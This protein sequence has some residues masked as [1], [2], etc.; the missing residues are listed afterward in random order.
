MSGS[1][2]LLLAFQA[3]L[4]RFSVL[5]KATKETKIKNV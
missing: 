3:T 4:F 2:Y 1:I 5:Q